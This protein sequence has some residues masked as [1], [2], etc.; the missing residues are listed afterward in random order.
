MT[1]TITTSAKRTANPGPNEIAILDGLL[2]PRK[3]RVAEC[4]SI[5]VTNMD[6]RP[7]RLYDRNNGTN[8]DVQIPASGTA[9][10]VAPNRDFLDLVLE[11]DLPLG[12]EYSDAKSQVEL[13]IDDNVNR[14]CN[15][16]GTSS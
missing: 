13:R 8:V 7:M 5:T 16:H 11:S 6:A 2:Y 15:Q 1:T 4:S 10:F 9:S 3:L 14:N 12:T